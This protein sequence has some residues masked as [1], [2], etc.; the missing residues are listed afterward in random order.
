MY[1][2]GMEMLSNKTI[3]PR[4][5][6]DWASLE[7]EEGEEQTKQDEVG[8]TETWADEGNVADKVSDTFKKSICVA[9]SVVFME[10]TKLD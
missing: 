1:R 7:E 5:Q 3:E 4:E 8:T 9:F 2:V 6:R 10:K